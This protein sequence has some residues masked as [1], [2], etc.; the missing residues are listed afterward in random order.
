MP[1]NTE[2]SLQELHSNIDFCLYDISK[3]LVKT[4]DQEHVNSLRNK[5]LKAMEDHFI[6]EADI[7]KDLPQDFRKKHIADH[8]F[9]WNKTK[10]IFRKESIDFEDF[11]NLQYIYAKHELE[12]DINLWPDDERGVLRD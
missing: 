9:L 8:Q 4:L 10:E 2:K 7:M 3:Q 6:L 1:I 12:F 11:F 5:L